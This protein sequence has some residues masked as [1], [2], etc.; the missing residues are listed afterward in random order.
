MKRMIAPVAQPDTNVYTETGANSAVVYI[1]CARIAR[2]Y[3]LHSAWT[4]AKLWYRKAVLEIRRVKRYCSVNGND[5][6]TQSPCMLCLRLHV[7]IGLTMMF[8]VRKVLNVSNAKQ[9][10]QLRFD[11]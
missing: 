9:Q 6:R 11:F 4:Q 3:D 5:L 7:H 2:D 10:I 8:L 1:L